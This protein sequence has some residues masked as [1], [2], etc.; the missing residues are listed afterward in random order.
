M[1]ETYHCECLPDIDQR[2][3]RRGRCPWCL[4]RLYPMVNGDGDECIECGDTFV[5]KLTFED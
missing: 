2:E 1:P 5:G 4:E 3:V